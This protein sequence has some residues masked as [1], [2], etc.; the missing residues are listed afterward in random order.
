M[1]YGRI[2][3]IVI[4]DAYILSDEP[5]EEN[6]WKTIYDEDGLNYYITSEVSEFVSDKIVVNDDIAE[7][8]FNIV[9]WTHEFDI[10]ISLKT[11]E[12]ST[13][14][15]NSSKEANNQ[16]TYNATVT[17]F[18]PPY[19]FSEN[20]SVPSP[21]FVTNDGDIKKISGLNTSRRIIEIYCGYYG[22]NGMNLPMVFRGKIENMRFIKNVNE[23]ELIIE[24]YVDSGDG[25]YITGNTF[26]KGMSFHQIIELLCK[27]AGINMGRMVTYV[28][29]EDG[30]STELKIK[31]DVTVESG[32]T[33]FQACVKIVK[34]INKEYNL[35][36][37]L[38][39]I[40]TNGTLDI[41]PSDW[42]YYRGFVITAKSGLISLEKSQKSDD[43][44]TELNIE[45]ADYNL[46]C[47]FIPEIKYK[48][49]VKVRFNESDEWKFLIVENI[50]HNIRHDNTAVT[51]LKCNELEMDHI[52]ELDS[53]IY[54]LDRVNPFKKPTTSYDVYALRG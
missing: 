27:R 52:E 4:S 19:E 30:E 13:A 35:E 16:K 32:S 53:E 39:V 48:E 17:I 1:R 47:L 45:Q 18:N 2:T 23:T 12:T 3:K 20:I 11:I 40:S 42:S 28:T 50:S 22:K 29:D 5:S 36:P 34:H 26:N 54:T 24:A 46:T 49:L 14:T 25:A 9:K 8:P 7:F 37:S 41:I 43:M 33:L 15:D 38:K 21:G 6:Y 31:D 51:E 44:D 10:D